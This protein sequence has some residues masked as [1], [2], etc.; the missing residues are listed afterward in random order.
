MD[1]KTAFL[2]REFEECV[3]MDMAEGVDIPANKPP[4]TEYAQAIVCLLPK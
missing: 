4:I 2:T 1:V 3:Y